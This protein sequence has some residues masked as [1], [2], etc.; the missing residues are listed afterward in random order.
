MRKLKRRKKESTSDKARDVVKSSMKKRRHIL[1]PRV[2]FLSSGCIVL[3]LALSG[4]GLKGGWG[5]GRIHNIVGDGSSGKTLLALELCFYVFKNIKKIVSK[6]YPKVKKVTIC[7]D[8]AEGVMDFPIEKMYGEDFYDT[9]DWT[10]SLHFEAMCRRFLKK[11]FALKKGEALIYVID[12]W[13]SFQSSSSKK[14]FLKSVQ[15]DTDLK[16]DYDLVVQKY[17]SR[18]FFPTF[19]DALDKN[20]LDATLVI[21]SQ[22]RD[23]IGVTFGK[24]QRRSGGKALNFY[25]HQVVWLREVERMAKTKLKRKRVYGI[26]SLA[27]VERSKVSK[28]FRE[29][30][31]RILF[32]Y[33][34]DDINAQIDFLW[35]NGKIKFNK[36][37]FKTRESFVKYIEGNNL[38]EELANH[39]ER[40]WTKVERLFEKEVERR[41]PRH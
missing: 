23:N 8:N 31:F 16:G 25:S 20:K 4:F 12:S 26:R 10:R 34:I 33:G 3:N 21:I 41:K 30:D 39:T 17:A 15:D 19:C 38:E 18:K 40:V 27:K 7:Y 9:V 35:G 37:G 2:E 36:K 32:D 29:A 11:A 28:P 1:N 13:D 24:K 6:I 22:V 5:R 14:A